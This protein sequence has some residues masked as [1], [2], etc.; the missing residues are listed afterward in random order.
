MTLVELVR[1][2]LFRKKLRTT[3]T[4]VAI[5]VAF[6]I[7]GVLATF[8]NAIN[9]GVEVAGADRL[10]TVNKINFTLPMPL[11]YPTRTAG[12]AGV[13]QVAHAEWFGGYYQ[14]PRNFL[15]AFAVDPK[16]YL[17]IYSELI[18]PPAQREAFLREKTSIIVGKASA[19]QYGW[20]VGDRLPLKSNIYQQKNG[21]DTWDFTIAGIYTGND[22]RVDTTPVIFHYDYLADTRSFGDGTTGWMI[23]KTADAKE[24]PRIMRE[25]DSLFA[26]SAFETETKTEQAFN[27]AFAEQLGDLGFIVTSVVG[28]AFVTILLIVGN[29]MMLTVRERTNEI[30]VLK[31]IG[32][33]TRRIFGMVIAES[34]LL[35]V[36]GGLLG[37]VVA[38]LISFALAGPLSRFGPVAFSFDTAAFAFVLMAL[39]GL[40]TGLIPAYRAMN[41]DIVTAFGR[42]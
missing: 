35:A 32:F 22:Q 4:I 24:N 14:E 33:T 29:T 12:V 15:V 17:D 28:A 34:M 38:W 2:N 36:I 40:L 42:K 5:F 41:T 23:L 3:L 8:Q 26:N 27:K 18:L 7:F 16:N 11:A 10:I 21:S 37:I 25:V 13:K 31:T 6:V 39:L 9:A 19:D 30:A 20:K 1:K